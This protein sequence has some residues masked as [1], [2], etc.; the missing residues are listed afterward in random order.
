MR[1]NFIIA[2]KCKVHRRLIP[3]T[4]SH[5]LSQSVSSISML[6]YFINFLKLCKVAEALEH[7]KLWGNVSI[8]REFLH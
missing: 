5:Q 8:H 4:W 1:V 2:P 3:R 7:R 6:L